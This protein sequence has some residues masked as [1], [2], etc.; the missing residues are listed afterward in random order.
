MGRST[1]YKEGRALV[2]VIYFNSKTLADGS[3]PFMLRITKNR[4]RKYIAT[5]L[6]LQPKFW[7]EKYTGYREAIRRTYPEPH[8]EKLIIELNHWEKKYSVV[9]ETLATTDEVHD[10]KAVATVAGERRKTLRRV[11][12]LAFIDELVEGMIAAKQIGNAGIYKD[13]RNQLVDFIQNE[14]SAL[15]VSFESVTVAFCNR[16]ETFLRT[17][18]NSEVTL[19]NRYRT[20]RAVLNRAIAEGVSKPDYYPFARNVAER[21]KFSVGKFD[22]S[23]TKR[24]ISR[25]DIRKVEALEPVGTATGKYALQ[26]NSAEVE[27]LRFAKAVFLFSFYCGG[28][29]FVDLAQIQWQ[30]ITTDS[31]GRQRLTY[32]RQKTNGKFSIRLLTPAAAI[33]NAYRSVTYVTS[34]SYVFPILNNNNHQTP[35][36]IKNRLHKVLGQVNDSL[37]TLGKLARIDVPLTT[38]VARHS[39]ATNLKRSGVATAI[40]SEAM[41][42]K[43]EAITGIYLD[44]FGSEIVDA[45]YE[46]LL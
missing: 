14:F 2:K 37:K 38:Y 29:N 12:L 23:T 20:L 3:H 24:A 15:D 32:V 34:S 26:I 30:N 10:A 21:H 18:G 35:S 44:S 11:Q 33:I 46:N 27:R 41:G 4:L 5:G 13:L 40:I 39:F 22:T 16:L 19:S 31:E 36:Q 42:H 45:A 1:D 25:D 7:N 43:T 6:S 8:R 9:A 28:I 17:R